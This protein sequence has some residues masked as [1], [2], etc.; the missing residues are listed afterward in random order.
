MGGI[1]LDLGVVVLVVGGAFRGHRRG[2]IREGLAFGGLAVGLLLASEWYQELAGIMAPFV[3]GGRLV[4]LVAYLGMV[5]AV[6]LGATLLTVVM[7]RMLRWLFIGWLDSMGGVLFGAAQG[8]LVALLVLF[9][10]VG[11]PVMGSDRAVGESLLSVALLE[12][13]PSVLA[14]LPPELGSIARVLELSR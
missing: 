6:L 13:L 2:L 10:L 9:V 5:L 1:L 7:R 12:S 8:A 3:G 4:A 11:Y 14:L